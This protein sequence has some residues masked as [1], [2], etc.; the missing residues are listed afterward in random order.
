MSGQHDRQQLAAS[1]IRGLPPATPAASGANSQQP[2]ASDPGGSATALDGLLNQRAADI[3]A[4]SVV[5]SATQQATRRGSGFDQSWQLAVNAGIAFSEDGGS[6]SEF[7]ASTLDGS[8]TYSAAAVGFVP[9]FRG[10][11]VDS[12]WENLPLPPAAP[13]DTTSWPIPPPSAPPLTT[14]SSVVSAVGS[15][16]YPAG[17]S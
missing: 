8:R 14:A 3:A 7:D 13:L 4:T 1:V 9:A 6:A 12:D 10:G 17:N 2:A 11:N 16:R 5:R 15:P